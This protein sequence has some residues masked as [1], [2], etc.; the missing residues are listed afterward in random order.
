MTTIWVLQHHPHEAL[1]TITGSL[2]A[3]GIVAKH[4]RTFDGE[5]VPA[6]VE[7][8]AGLIVMGGPMGVYELSRYPFLVEEMRLIE[9]A[10]RAE[11]P[12]LGVCLGSQLL[13]A[14]L[15]AQVT[16]GKQKEIGWHRVTLTEPARKD[17]L[18]TGIEATFMGFHWHG[19]VFELPRGAVSLASSA[20]TSCQAFRYNEHAYGLL[21]RVEVTKPMIQNW[22]KAFAEG[23]RGARID[24][25]EIVR[26]ADEHL[27]QLQRIGGV[28]VQR[29]ASLIER[30]D[31]STRQESDTA[32]S[33]I[34]QY[35]EQDH[36]RLD[37]LFKR[38]RIL[39]TANPPEA[40]ACFLEFQASL[41]RHIVWEEEILFPLFEAKTGMLGMGPTHVMRF[42]HQQIK[43]LLEA[44]RKSL[45]QGCVSDTEEQALV[46][47][48]DAHNHKE[49]HI[50]YP[51]IEAQLTERERRGV[52]A[53]MEE[54]PHG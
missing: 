14:T 50:L 30:R 5:P 22:V 27:P 40:E 41:L 3:A 21:F 16:R 44:I 11:K 46:E 43:G 19:D 8:T 35:Y 18:W 1:G 54:V 36:D 45:Q 20:L 25:D 34:A 47:L 42:E 53:R 49:E 28:V 38:F 7:E 10:L 12:V 23:L 4:I 13:A 17:C 33:S 52:F 24:G 31:E 48:L 51:A 39:K 32:M 6:G 15:G 2:E 37:E 26:K 9:Q 29:W